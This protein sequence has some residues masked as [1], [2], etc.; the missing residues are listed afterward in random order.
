MPLKNMLCFERASSSCRLEFLN[1]ST[2]YKKITSVM[3]CSRTC[4]RSMVEN[5]NAL[6]L[7]CIG[8]EVISLNNLAVYGKQ[9]SDIDQL[10][11]NRYGQYYRL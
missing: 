1:S 10:L 4:I 7:I 3:F 8:D 5:M 6:C 9:A 11:R 2:F